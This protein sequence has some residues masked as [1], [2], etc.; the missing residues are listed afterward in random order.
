MSSQ[1][2]SIVQEYDEVL[3]PLAIQYL[4]VTNGDN[5]VRSVR[6]RPSCNSASLCRQRVATA[7][8]IMRI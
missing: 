5:G 4:F 3:F 1:G 7:F 8:G 2:D 6:P